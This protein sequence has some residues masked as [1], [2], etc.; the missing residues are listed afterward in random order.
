M[1]ADDSKLSY[2][3]NPKSFDPQPLLD[4]LQKIYEWCQKWGL[5]LAASKTVVLHLGKYNPNFQYTLNGMPLVAQKEVRDLGI[6]ISNNL[7]MDSHVKKIVR[8]AKQKIYLL[9]KILKT[10][11]PEI[12]IKAYNSY[13]RPIVEAS[14]TLFSPKNVTLIDSIEN[15]QRKVTRKI[16]LRCKSKLLQ[17]RLNIPKYLERCKIL[18]LQTLEYRRLEAD[19]LF[20]IRLLQN[21]TIDSTPYV[22]MVTVR[23]R[24]KVC[25][26]TPGRWK[27]SNHFYSTIP[28]LTRNLSSIVK[29]FPDIL[30]L[31]TSDAIKFR[32]SE[33]DDLSLSSNSANFRY[34][35][36]NIL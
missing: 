7:S 9:F 27:L 10:N 29:N 31:K 35:P 16:F 24:T 13:V 4:T 19:A 34:Q 25:Y 3:Y 15:V 18:K 2:S 26:R 23:T 30:N 20:G 14:S 36:I 21:P 5:S 12:L 1:F 22:T 28:R 6:T 11:D 32:V 17:N 8:S 33:V